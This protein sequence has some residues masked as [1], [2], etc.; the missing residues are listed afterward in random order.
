MLEK[1]NV[2]FTKL[3]PKKAKVTRKS[4]DGKLFDTE[5]LRK[6]RTDQRNH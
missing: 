1:K 5:K 6:R 3:E 4:D 2:R